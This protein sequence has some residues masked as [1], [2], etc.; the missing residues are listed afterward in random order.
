MAKGVVRY[1]VDLI[2]IPTGE[3]IYHNVPIK[4]AAETL[5][6]SVKAVRTRMANSHSKELVYDNYMIK[7]LSY[8]MPEFQEERYIPSLEELVAEFL[9]VCRKPKLWATIDDDFCGEFRNV[10]R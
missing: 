3:V 9:R 4:Q 8:T 7:Q 6:K 1:L 2:Y 10:A 5:K